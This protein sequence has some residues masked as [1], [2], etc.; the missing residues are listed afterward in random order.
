[1]RVRLVLSAL[2]L[3]ALASTA[4]ANHR[5]VDYEAYA[6]EPIRAFSFSQL[7]NWQRVTDHRMV[8]WTKPGTA[9]LLDLRNNCDALSGRVTVQ[10]GGV[11]GVPGRLEAGMGEVVVGQLRCRVDR[12][13]PLDLAR[14][15]ADRRAAAG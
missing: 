2:L 7:Y 5:S 14:M 12:I 1:M 6:G 11:D 13:R 8:V 9:Y 4:Q 3:A 15:K 10:I